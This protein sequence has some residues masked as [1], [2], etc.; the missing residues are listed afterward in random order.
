MAARVSPG[1]HPARTAIREERHGPGGP[2]MA[3]L[4]SIG[5]SPRRGIGSIP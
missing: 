2:G 5:I 3:S 4:P 1:Y